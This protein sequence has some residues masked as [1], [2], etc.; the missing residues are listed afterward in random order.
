MIDKYSRVTPLPD[1]RRCVSLCPPSFPQRSV[2]R[3][4]R[5]EIPEASASPILICLSRPRISVLH[6]AARRY[7]RQLLRAGDAAIAASEGW[8]QAEAGG[9]G[10]GENAIA[11]LILICMPRPRFALPRAAVA[12]AAGRVSGWQG[13]SSGGNAGQVRPQTGGKGGIRPW[14]PDLRSQGRL[15]H[16]TRPTPNRSF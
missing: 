4:W 2:P 10:R 14:S 8:P 15:I 13:E 6:L 7:D 12:A 1:Q 9:G 5:K 3:P 11:S 16:T